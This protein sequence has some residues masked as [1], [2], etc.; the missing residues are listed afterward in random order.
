MC[1]LGSCLAAGRFV[2]CEVRQEMA[3]SHH[4]VALGLPCTRSP[5]IGEMVHSEV[6]AMWGPRVLAS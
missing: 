4:T 1:A 6:W 3:L 2:S 5:L